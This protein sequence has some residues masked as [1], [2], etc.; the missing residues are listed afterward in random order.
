MA[1]YGLPTI[2]G[3]GGNMFLSELKVNETRLAS[4]RLLQSDER[5]HAVVM[6]SGCGERPLWRLDDRYAGKVLY[7]FSRE[8]PDFTGFVEQ[9]GWPMKSYEETV[10]T[11]D[12]S[13]L[14][15]RLHNGQKWYFQTTVNP[16]VRV[17]PSG[18]VVPLIKDA[19]DDWLV[20][21]LES[22]A[23]VVDGSLKLVNSHNSVFFKDG[24]K[25]TVRKSV[26]RGIIKLVDAD[27]FLDCIASGIGR[28]KAYG[29]GLLTLAPYES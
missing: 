29:C 28:D 11:V 4:I 17:R 16:T 24:R 6:K 21:K 1:P 8:R 19:A 18:K 9:Y 15:G 20:R 12:F 22:Y 13:S 23:N 3:M 7:V 2:V 25:V 10:R 5:I 27:G 26:Y 14:A